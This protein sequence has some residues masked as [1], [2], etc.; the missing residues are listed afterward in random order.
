MSHV[1]F[2][3]HSFE[4]MPDVRCWILLK[5]RINIFYPALCIQYPVSGSFAKLYL[6]STIILGF[7][8]LS[9]FTG[10]TP[11]TALK[12]KQVPKEIAYTVPKWKHIGNV[13]SETPTVTRVLKRYTGNMS[14]AIN[15]IQ[16]NHY[17]YNKNF[18][19]VLPFG[20][21]I[22]ISED[23]ELYIN[24]NGGKAPDTVI[25]RREPNPEYTIKQKTYRDSLT[26][27]G[28]NTRAIFEEDLKE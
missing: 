13:S 27:D 15:I 25:I 26:K 9:L 17:K 11:L 3:R 8:F 24:P 2:K 6:P 4:V 14:A 5:N 20:A 1:F 10:C 18:Y 12:K 23:A 28:G 16:S 19:K 7:L 22:Y 21:S